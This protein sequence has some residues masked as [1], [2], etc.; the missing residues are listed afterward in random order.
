MA[1]PLARAYEAAGDRERARRFY[2]WLTI[3]WRDADP[4]LQP[5]VQEAREALQR[6]GS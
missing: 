2:E 4:E 1:L 5:A 6:L 3:A